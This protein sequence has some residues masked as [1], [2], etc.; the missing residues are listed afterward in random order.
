MRGGKRENAGRKRGSLATKTRAIAEKAAS[1]GITPLEVMLKAMRVHLRARRWD[2]AAA[3]AKDAAPYMHPR[4]TAVEVG[5]P[6]GAIELVARIERVIVDP[7]DSDP[8]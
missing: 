8:A 4:L 6:N 5:G 1:Q 2:Q 7:D 3:V